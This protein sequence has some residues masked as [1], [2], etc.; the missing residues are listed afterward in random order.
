MVVFSEYL[1]FKSD[2]QTGTYPDEHDEERK[3]LR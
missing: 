2:K 1:P 3:K